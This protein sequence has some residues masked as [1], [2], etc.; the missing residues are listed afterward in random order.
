MKNTVQINP[1]RMAALRTKRGLSQKELA[2]KMNV[3]VGTV[4][5]WERGKSKRIRRDAF[6][7]LCSALDVAQDEICGDGPLPENRTE[8]REPQK[9]QMNLSVDAAC[10]NALSL[11]ALRYR[12]TRQ[13]IVEAAPLLFF[14]AAEKSL[15]ER[16]KRLDALQAAAD[17]V[18]EA[19][20]PHL[21]IP[22]SVDEET[23]E[24]ERRSIE[25]HDLF[26]SIVTDNVNVGAHYAE[27]WDEG[28][29]NSLTVFLKASLADV[30]D[31]ATFE[32]WQPGLWPRYEI[33]A[34]EAAKVVGGDAKATRAILD[35]AAALHEMPKASPQE[36]AEW[37]RAEFDRKYGDLDCL[38]DDL[39]DPSLTKVGGGESAASNEGTTP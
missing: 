13:Q 31:S 12:V 20:P 7:K 22:A 28:E 10:R 36:R 37:S 35:G 8:S 3:D 32:H 6:G 2:R 18:Y 38:T 11:V 21:P 27:G 30:S 16:C 14:I 5:R 29:S 4:S 24:C 19:Y 33:C 1:E 25:A 17:A 9:G 34:E 15:Q 26:G 23:L 39:I